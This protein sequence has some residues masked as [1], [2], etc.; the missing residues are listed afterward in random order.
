MPL[1]CSIG[2]PEYNG[3]IRG[4]PGIARHS[5]NALSHG[6]SANLERAV[7]DVTMPENSIKQE[8]REL[9]RPDRSEIRIARH[10]MSIARTPE[11]LTS[12]MHHFRAANRANRTNQTS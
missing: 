10:T 3:P 9:F 1:T 12:K 8:E 6:D 11:N 2:V 7:L 5:P 4:F